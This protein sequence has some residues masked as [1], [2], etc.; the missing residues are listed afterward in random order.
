MEFIN[1]LSG[2]DWAFL[3][4]GL[5]TWFDAIPTLLSKQ[6]KLN[7]QSI[8]SIIDK[9]LYQIIGERNLKGRKATM[10]GLVYFFVGLIFILIAF[11]DILLKL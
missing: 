5:F 9:I 11:G 6:R 10:V 1:R 3:V 8:G 4:F 7:D 2:L